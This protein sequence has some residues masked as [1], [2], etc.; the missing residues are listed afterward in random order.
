GGALRHGW[1]S[2]RA[3]WLAVLFVAGLVL[4]S[5]PAT[6]RELYALPLFPAASAA[7]GVWLSRVG[8]RRESRIDRATLASLTVLAGSALLAVGGVLAY[9]G[10]NG[11]LPEKA[12]RA[13]DLIQHAAGTL[14]LMLVAAVALVAGV[15]AVGSAIRFR[16]ASPAFGSILTAA[17]LLVAVFLGHAAFAPL[18]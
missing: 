2:G 1:R 13:A 7:I 11:K 3:R 16:G 12:R 9:V 17:S 14:R 8:T 4:L 18:L 15:L 6:K 10:A 5:V